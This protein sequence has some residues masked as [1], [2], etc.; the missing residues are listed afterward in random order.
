MALKIPPDLIKASREGRLVLFIGNGLSR[1]ATNDRMP[2]WKDFINELGNLALLRAS[3]KRQ[4]QNT[5]AYLGAD[6]V[7][8]KLGRKL[9]RSIS[10][11]IAGAPPIHSKIR[12]LHDLPFKFIITTNFDSFIE[13]SEPLAGMH[14]KPHV[15]L[16]SLPVLGP[17]QTKNV[18]HTIRAGKSRFIFKIH[19]DPKLGNIVLS[20]GSYYKLLANP[21]YLALMH[22]IF[23]NY[24][25]LFLGFGL[26][27]YDFNT[28]YP[29]IARLLQG[30]SEKH[31]ALMRDANGITARTFNRYGIRVLR[32]DFNSFFNQ[33]HQLRPI[34][35]ILNLTFLGLGE[36]PLRLVKA[37]SIVAPNWVVYHSGYGFAGIQDSA[38]HL[39]RD[40]KS[41]RALSVRQL[42]VPTRVGRGTKIEITLR[43]IG[44]FE[45]FIL[46]KRGDTLSYV[47]ISTEDDKNEGLHQAD[48]PYFFL[49]P[50][51]QDIRIEADLTTFVIELD[52]QRLPEIFRGF[53]Q[54]IGFFV[55]INQEAWIHQIRVVNQRNAD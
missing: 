15:R 7:S 17:A 22:A 35:P 36:Q 8:R 21:D 12:P 45:F 32:G 10:Q 50:R 14:V 44:T 55:G 54:M 51:E 31:F 9:A 29:T 13:D 1:H 2:L 20:L 5:Q 33:I 52:N 18:L 25:V 40:P 42:I 6:Y 27:D 16:S 48:M 19:G 3:E 47:A 43:V 4:L 38:L 49:K 41:P 34:H 24:V 28:F 39:R 37:G 23:C 11:V 46:L 53:E 26:D 30:S